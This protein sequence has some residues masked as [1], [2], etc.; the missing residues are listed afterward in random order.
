[1][2]EI[3]PSDN[4]ADLVRGGVDV[5]DTFD[6]VYA[7]KEQCGL[8]SLRSGIAKMVDAVGWGRD[9]DGAIWREVDKGIWWRGKI[10]GSRAGEEG[11]GDGDS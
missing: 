9:L 2:P 8:H 10:G 3:E 7:R 1:M 6:F 11:E 5:F 4:N